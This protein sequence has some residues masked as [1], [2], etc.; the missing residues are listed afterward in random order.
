MLALYKRAITPP[1][2][3]MTPITITGA[4]VSIAIFVL[5]VGVGVPKTIT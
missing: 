3:P 2:T 4:P 5:V 1:T